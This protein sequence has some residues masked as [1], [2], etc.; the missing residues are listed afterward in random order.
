MIPDYLLSDPH[1]LVPKLETATNDTVKITE[2]CKLTFIRDL[3]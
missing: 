3:T 2:I 1:F